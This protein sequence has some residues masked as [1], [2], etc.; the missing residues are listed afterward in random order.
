MTARFLLVLLLAAA[1]SPLAFLPAYSAERASEA[2]VRMRTEI[3][4]TKAELERTTAELKRLKG[5]KSDYDS[6]LQKYADEGGELAGKMLKSIG[7]QIKDRAIDTPKKFKDTMKRAYEIEKQYGETASAGADAAIAKIDDEIRE[8]DIPRLEK[9][10][11][12]L[13]RDLGYKTF[14]YVVLGPMLQA[15]AEEEE[16]QQKGRNEKSG[17]YYKVLPKAEYFRD[18]YKPLPPGTFTNDANPNSNTT[19]PPSPPTTSSETKTPP[20]TQEAPPVTPP[21]QTAPPQK[22]PSIDNSDPT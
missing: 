6:K 9:R 7:D 5:V 22:Q 19:P 15:K 18:N 10:S 20:V 17:Q 2:L 21:P 11:E 12:R 8:I 13:A 14:Q 1:Y 16:R 4:T 3:E